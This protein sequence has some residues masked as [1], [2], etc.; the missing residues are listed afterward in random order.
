MGRK[1]TTL[2]IDEELYDQIR[3]RAAQR[4]VSMS[5]VV[6]EATTKYLAEASLPRP[7][8]ELPRAKG[9]MA[10]F[11]PHVNLDSATAIEEYL[12]SLDSEAH[13]RKVDAS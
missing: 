4:R 10:T 6:A 5:D 1:K 7:R 12:D 11:P 13:D 9:V 2:M 3:L 8:I